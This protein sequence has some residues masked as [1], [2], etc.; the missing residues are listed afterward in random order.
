M[1]LENLKEAWAALDNRLKRNEKLKESIILD[2][3]RSKTRKLLNKVITLEI[4][5]VVVAFLVM[6]FCIFQ[7]YRTYELA[8]NIFLFFVVAVCFFH[9]FWGGF[10][11]HGL[12]KIN[13]SNNIGRNFYYMN[14]YTIQIK[15]ERK[16]YTY[17]VLIPLTIMVIVSLSV[18]ERYVWWLFFIVS[19]PVAYWSNLLYTL[20]HHK[21][22]GLIF[23]SLDEIRELKEE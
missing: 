16:I 20:P 18:I 5:Y 3:M 14:R 1:E 2:M 8:A 6:S 19:L 10:K 13:L 4:I 17:Y 23:K 9:F 7:I 22:V 11:I 21:N 15:R 12:M